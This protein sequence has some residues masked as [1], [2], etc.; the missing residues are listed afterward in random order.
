MLIGR[1]D[2][3]SALHACIGARCGAG[4]C[5]C[6]CGWLADWSDR[7]PVLAG[8]AGG[9]GEGVYGVWVES[10]TRL[11]AQNGRGGRGGWGF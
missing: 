3:L 8:L 1:D 2:I 9:R 6:V 4:M 11:F 10:W 5:S 7:M